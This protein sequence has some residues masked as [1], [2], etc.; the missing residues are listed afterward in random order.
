MAN[1]ARED[2]Q[3]RTVEVNRLKLVETLKANREAHNQNYLEA[4]E[5]YKALALEK[6]QDGYEAAKVKLDKNLDRGKLAL[7]Q[8]DPSS[9]KDSAD[10][11]VLVEG[12]NVELRVP[13]NFSKEYD[14]AID[15]ASWD[16]RETLELTHAEFQCFVRDQWDW[17][18]DFIRTTAIYSTGKAFLK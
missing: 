17:T 6:L 3:K 7:E 10:W 11:L 9:P 14:A 12:I 18:T 4:V 8:F 13:R 2:Q 1:L 5:G 15:M 16:V